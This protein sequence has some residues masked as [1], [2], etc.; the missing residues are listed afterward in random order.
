VLSRAQA[1]E[2]A[3][4]SVIHL[5]IGQPDFRTPEHI[6][7][8]A[9]RAVRDG[10]TGYCATEGIASLRQAISDAVR[11]SRGVS[12]R[13]S[14]VIVTS[15]AKPLLF[16]AALAC[17]EPGDEVIYPD[18]GFPIYESVIRFVGAIP[19]PLPLRESRDFRFDGDELCRLASNK[20]RMLIL[21]TPQNPTGGVLGDEE[22][23]AIADVARRFGFWVLADEVYSRLTYDEPHRSILAYDGMPEQTILVDG[24][25]KTYAM[26]GW[27]LGWGVMPEPLAESVARL[28]VNSNSCTATF[29][30]HAGVAALRGPQDAVA[31]MR[32]EFRA[33]RDLLVNGLN[34]IR[35]IRCRVP[36]GAFYAF[37]NVMA[38]TDDD[39][40]FVERLLDD[41]G[42]AALWGSS[43]GKGGKGY[44]RLSYANSRERLSEALSRIAAFVERAYPTIRPDALSTSE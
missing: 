29:V 18:P 5:E 37:P 8:A 32:R 4:R 31:A 42:V 17:L 16:Y 12:V 35:G 26:T 34:A 13:E 43:F 38:L 14:Q 24:A 11:A 41:V 44:L 23:S 2:S 39:R 21:N 6:C 36:Q 20:T 3:G 33:R 1:L 9:F 30:Q 15:G 22:L 7:E 40:T 25:S 28:I 10:A 27:R 19:V